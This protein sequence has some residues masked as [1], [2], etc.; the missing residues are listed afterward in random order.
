MSSYLFILWNSLLYICLTAHIQVHSVPTKSNTTTRQNTPTGKKSIPQKRA[1]NI[2]AKTVPCQK[3]API[4]H[5]KNFLSLDLPA[6][7]AT[8]L[9]KCMGQHVCCLLSKMRK[10]HSKQ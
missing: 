4:P 7:Q 9:K 10:H 8:I 1:P 5:E 2:V 3:Q 6:A